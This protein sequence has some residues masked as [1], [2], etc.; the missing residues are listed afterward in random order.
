M[1]HAQPQERTQLAAWLL[2]RATPREG[3]GLPWTVQRARR[4]REAA[5]GALA[6]CFAALPEQAAEVAL[7]VGEGRWRA[8]VPREVLQDGRADVQASLAQLAGRAGDAALLP[9]I[10]AALPSARPAAARALRVLVEQALAQSKKSKRERDELA[11][12]ALRIAMRATQEHGGQPDLTAALLIGL[13]S[14]RGARLMQGVV[15]DDLSHE[16]QR[17]LRT[18]PLA[19]ARARALAWCH[20][21]L[22]SR[23]CIVRLSRTAS[24]EEHA[25][26]LERWHLALRPS[27]QSALAQVPVRLAGAH[28][29]IGVLRAKLR[30]SPGLALPSPAVLR[31]L[32]TQG[33]MG[34]IVLG[35]RL[36]VQA[37]VREAMLE[38]LLTED[39]ACVRHALARQCPQGLLRELAWDQDARVARSSLLLLLARAEA[40]AEIGPAS[41]K[42][43]ASSQSASTSELAAA[44]EPD[45]ERESTDGGL[46]TQLAVLAR[47]PHAGV[48][49]LAEVQA[50]TL[51]PQ[52]R[53]DAYAAMHDPA[54]LAHS[55]R[56]LLRRGIEAHPGETDL[57]S[58]LERML[59]TALARVR[60][61]RLATAL[62][63][64]L[65]ELC[66][67][68]V[69]GTR[70]RATSIMVLS[71]SGSLLA[72]RAIAS[73]LHDPDAR[74]RANAIEA[75]GLWVRRFAS[76]PH[77][78]T[79]PGSEREPTR[80]RVQALARERCTPATAHRERANAALVSAELV[81]GKDDNGLA[82]GLSTAL[83]MLRDDNAMQRAAGLWLSWRL[84]T[85]LTHERRLSAR[86]AH[87]IEPQ[88]SLA[89]SHESRAMLL[90][91][92]EETAEHDDLA[93]LRT[94]SASLAQWLRE[95][96][97]AA[98]WGAP[99]KHIASEDRP[100]HAGAIA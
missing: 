7:V 39:Q 51:A 6:Q 62:E 99:A 26:V 41:R 1:P 53:Q 34:A 46:A 49:A 56:A 71:R 40:R 94:R 78:S 24:T 93:P 23:A 37:R 12:G 52:R 74:V 3:R 16:L 22:L 50:R 77:E 14:Q 88:G 79:A 65:A 18:S 44:D 21:K 43:T 57:G 8:C 25:M 60:S 9:W 35:A 5:L 13:D 11:M 100:L 10:E 89:P 32:S 33:R 72:R 95:G 17:A 73:R 75:L 36:H 27:R 80:T 20:M 48:R 85:K 81:E 45:A 30:A 63:A 86:A 64:E 96:G 4:T 84:A 42:R 29:P 19:I 87:L 47:S 15:S 58:T 68:D 28:A 91:A 55:L 97:P 31:A 82:L 69:C 54:A 70:V 92:V 90:A 83:S 59:L 66:G 38:P 98:P 61:G 67:S 2:E 76:S